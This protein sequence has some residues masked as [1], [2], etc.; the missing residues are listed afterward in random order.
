[1]KAIHYKKIIILLTVILFAFLPSCDKN[2]EEPEGPPTLAKITPIKDVS[3]TLSGGN[4]GDWIAIFGQNLKSTYAIYFNDVEVDMEEVYYENNV[5]YLQV[6]IKIPLNVSDQLKI[7]TPGGEASYNFVVG[8]PDLELT[9]MF[10]EYTLPGDTIK[11]YGR[12]LDLYEIDSDNTVVVFGDIQTPVIENGSTYIT[13]KVPTNV[14][15]NVKVKAINSKYD[16][17]AICPGF[18]QDKNNVITTFDDDFPYGGSVSNWASIVA[19]IDDNSKPFSS[20]NCLWFYVNQENAPN[21]LG[22]WYLMENSYAFSEDMENNP[23]DYVLKFELR[24]GNPINSTNF[25]VYNRWNNDN[26]LPRLSGETFVV[27]EYN[28][29]QTITVPFETLYLPTH[30]YPPTNLNFRVESFAPVE[31]V[32]MYLDNFRMYK[33]GD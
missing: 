27:L 13:A 21:G 6:P 23:G 17:V 15:A 7:I 2:T 28:Q 24:M 12:F 32:N 11:I 31:P 18:Y 20:G 10:N 22:W 25:F 9:A 14:Q 16:A 29:W 33:K 4:M 19:L 26:P 5:L 3:T 30:A 8:V 1:M